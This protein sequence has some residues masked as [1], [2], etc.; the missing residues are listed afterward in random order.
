MQNDKENTVQTESKSAFRKHFTGRRI[1]FMAV[2]VALSYAV[3]FLEFPIFPVTPYLKLDFSNAFIL[4][5]TFLLGPIEGVVVCILKELLRFIGSNSSGVGEIANVVVN[6]SFILLP[7]ILYRFKKGFKVVIP[8]L[9]VACIIGTCMALVVNR[10][11][12][13]P[14]YW[15]DGA[16]AMYNDVF[17]LIV[18]FN[19]IKTVSVSV[20]TLLLYKRLSKVLKKIEHIE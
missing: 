11:V 13:F 3:S 7:G 14:L 19:L 15:G 9:G 18:A 1:V 12:T 17:W 4:L 20:I 16:T 10:F 8:A 5:I 2:F 6:S